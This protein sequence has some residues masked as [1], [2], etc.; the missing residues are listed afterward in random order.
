MLA[1]VP[2]YVVYIFDPQ[3]WEWMVNMS[4]AHWHVGFSTFQEPRLNRHNT[5][6]LPLPSTWDHHNA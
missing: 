3:E 5:N 4:I 6:A 1:I 2:D